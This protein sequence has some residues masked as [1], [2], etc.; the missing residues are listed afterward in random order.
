MHR[1]GSLLCAA[2]AAIAAIGCGEPKC[3]VG[4][5]APES[6]T[7]RMDFAIEGDF[8]AAPFPSDA[9]RDESGKPIVDGFPNPQSVFLVDRVL[10]V[11]RSGADGFGVSS[12]AFFS[13][14]GALDPASLPTMVESTTAEASVFLIAI[15]AGS[16]DY[17]VRQPVSVRFSED[18]GL[19]GPPNMLSVVPLQ[20]AP[21]R[22]S[23]RYAVVI[24]TAVRAA[25][26]APL[27]V[28][29]AVKAIIDGEEVAGMTAAGALESHRDAIEAAVSG[30]SVSRESIAAL[31]V[32]TTGDPAAKM[33]TALSDAQPDVM[34][35]SM[36]FAKVDDFPTFCV[37]ASTI[38]MPVY[39]SGEPPYSNA[40]GGWQSD[41]E[42]R[43]VLDHHETARFFITI[44]K[45]TMPAAGYPLV[46]FSRTGAGGDRALV[47][48]GVRAEAGGEATPGTGPALELAAV[49]YA[50][51][52]I[53]GP[54]GG[55]RNV[56]GGDEQFLVF[57]FEN[58]LALRDNIRQS[59]L[60]L[61][62]VP[63]ILDGV[64]I[65]VSD[66][67]GAVAPGDNATIDTGTRSWVTR[68]ALRSRRS[69]S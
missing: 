40:D 61:A 57:N 43:L 2:V 69:P 20:G 9:R 54:H 29:A 67:A 53:D 17:A 50:G 60:E 16:P 39:Q 37:F 66:C 33:Q 44:P 1:W 30:A 7:V 56:T 31:T 42:G 65:D 47:D 18:P 23:Q 34:A 24:T 6:V 10:D 3:D 46:V 15:D 27:E 32:F 45:S 14:T 11:I 48:R 4:C 19:Y 22:P 35:P 12:G 26:G 59:A 8:F 41:A 68:W 5:V 55:I 36:P 25:D 13:T 38:E 58:P 64:A 62:L 52:S 51:A 28:S 21:L 49:G 63:G